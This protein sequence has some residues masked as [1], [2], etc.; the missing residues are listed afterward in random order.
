MLRFASRAVMALGFVALVAGCQGVPGDFKPDPK[1]KTASMGQLQ[2]G[3]RDVCIKAQRAKSSS[4]TAELTKSCGCYSGKAL[5]SMDKGEIDFY[6]SN[7]FFADSARPKAQAA[8][9]SCGLS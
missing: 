7:G 2:T 8:L 1:L 4:S 6:R 5:K 3:V 9:N